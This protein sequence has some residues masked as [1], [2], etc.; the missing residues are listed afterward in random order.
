MRSWRISSAK[1][2]YLYAF[3]APVE[4]HIMQ[5]CSSLLMADI[6]CKLQNIVF[7]TFSANTN[8]SRSVFCNMSSIFKGI[9]DGPLISER[10]KRGNLFDVLCCDIS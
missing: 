3:V 5:I 8:I 7:C 2:R 10:N 6:F 4:P 1:E 9:G